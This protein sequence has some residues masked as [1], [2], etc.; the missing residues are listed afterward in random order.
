MLKSVPAVPPRGFPLGNS[1]TRADVSSAL[2]RFF[3]SV[4]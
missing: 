3:V 4:G 2:F 1:S